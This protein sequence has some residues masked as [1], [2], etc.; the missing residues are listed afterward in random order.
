MPRAANRLEY[1][2][3][4]VRCGVPRHGSRPLPFSACAVCAANKL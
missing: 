3:S 2:A 4:K 1:C